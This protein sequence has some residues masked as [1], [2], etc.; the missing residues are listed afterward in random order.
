MFMKSDADLLIDTGS[1][2]LYE[3]AQVRALLTLSRFKEDN[4]KLARELLND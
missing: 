3:L 1:L 2:P 4:K